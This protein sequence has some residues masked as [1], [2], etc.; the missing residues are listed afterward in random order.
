MENSDSMFPFFTVNGL[1]FI[2]KSTKKVLK[3]PILTRKIFNLK[4]RKVYSFI[5]KYYHDVES[6]NNKVPIRKNIK[7]NN[8]IWT[9]WLQGLSKSPEIVKMGFN[10]IKSKSNGHKV[11][12]I[13]EN[14]FREYIPDFSERIFSQYRKGKIL[15]AHF[16][17]MVRVK[18]IVRYGGIWIDP[19]VFL[20]KK[21]N[22]AI[23]EESFSSYRTV[24]GEWHSNP[25]D[26]LW[27]TFYMG[28]EANDP[29]F[30]L[31]DD[32]LNNYWEN[33]Q[34]HID[35]FLLDYV[36]KYI[37]LR[38]DDIRKIVDK[39]EISNISAFSLNP[40]LKENFNSEVSNEINK[41]L[42]NGKLF[43]LSYKE[44]YDK[45]SFGLM[46]DNINIFN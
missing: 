25:A 23:F 6:I 17:D 5:S 28:G 1:N 21:I 34:K 40:L 36:M 2:G 7:K 38:N 14:N 37:Y 13:D 22:N 26:S 16:M 46:I 31:T 39:N 9:G 15:P 42:K 44:K 3:S 11:I 10:N 24:P 19:T 43:K 20:T 30:S 29:F 4:D 32:M 41:K 8:V 35:Y 45:E 12:F 27:C 18:L 33:N